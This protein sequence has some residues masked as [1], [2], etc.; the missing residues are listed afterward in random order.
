MGN[1]P[2]HWLGGSFGR[3]GSLF[4]SKISAVGGTEHQVQAPDIHQTQEV[5]IDR[6]TDRV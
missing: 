3:E 1:R 5:G 6:R 4:R 2:V